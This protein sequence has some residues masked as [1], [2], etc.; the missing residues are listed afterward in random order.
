[1]E[2]YLTPLKVAR[3]Q[4]VS[5]KTVYR[6]FYFGVRG[7]MLKGFKVGGRWRIQRV[8]LNSFIKNCA[9]RRK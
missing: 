7:Y 1:M 6:W 4:G 9:W 8:D 3:L 5:K 2:D